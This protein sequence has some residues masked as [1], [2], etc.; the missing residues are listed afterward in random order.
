MIAIEVSQRAERLVA[1]YLDHIVE[2]EPV[3]A[4]RLGIDDRNAEL[5][6]LSP[7]ELAARSRDLA[8]LA[9]EVDA[10]LE[11][12]GEPA[13]GQV[14]EARDDLVLLRQTLEFR[15]FD[16]DVRP[17]YLLDPLAALDTIG[18]GVH[19]LISDP[20]ASLE[21]RRE[22]VTAA[23]RRAECTPYLLEQAGGL[24]VSTPTVHL[25]VAFQRLRG[26]I[27]LMRVELPR[28]ASELG[29][30]VRAAGAAGE[31]AGEG[32]EAYAALLHE[33]AEEPEG[34]WRL[35]SRHHAITLRTGLGTTLDPQQIEDRART[36]ITQVRD[37]LAEISGHG[38]SR[39][40]PGEALP[41]D[42]VERIRRTLDAVGDTA[43]PR[44]HLV[45]EARVAVDEARAFAIASGL[46]DVPPRERLTVTEVPRHLR[47]IAVA[48]L[49]QAPPLR[50]ARGCTYY[51]SAVPQDWDE[52]Q[53]RSFLREYNA[54]QLR[55][56]AIHEG[57]PGHFVQLEHAAKHPR[58]A[59]RLLARPVFAE[60]WAVYA[61]REMAAAGFGEGASSRVDA[62]DYRLTQRKLELRLAANALLDIGL[63][64]GELADAEALRLLTCTAFQEHAEAEGK[65]VR[66]KVTSGQ[67]SSYFVGGEE[68]A[69]LRL[70]EERRLG[71]RFDLRSFHQ[72][73]L[74]HGTPTTSIVA[75]ALADDA[76]VRRPFASVAT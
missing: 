49:A 5:P 59:R 6:D 7:E 11:L 39:R 10:A 19:E 68:F 17:R 8:V 63:H 18:A 73:V 12:V 50:P 71:A 75:E 14:R 13:W 15:R 52:E 42:P 60:G 28:H 65:L 66:A 41:S 70:A 32:L 40:F 47:G 76:P 16:L 51:L 53:A 56:L 9:A 20:S 29:L 30:D 36:W 2:Y 58:L 74:S 31:L 55:S 37:E 23:V 3:E 44:E 46:T 43:V 62:D 45:D 72:R 64:A 48:F 67:L 61:E 38:W 35:G 57:Y 25:R 4:S 34:A 22:R 24:L 69:D 54:A 33:L 27:D 21:E 26:L 1:R